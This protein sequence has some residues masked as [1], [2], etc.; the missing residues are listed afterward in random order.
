[1]LP[2]SSSHPRPLQLLLVCIVTLWSVSN[3]LVSPSTSTKTKSFV[4]LLEPE[5]NCP[6]FL[7]G[8][9]HGSQS[10]ASDVRDL[11]LLKNNKNEEENTVVVL[12][13]CAS[14]MA[15]LRRQ[16]PTLKSPIQKQFSLAGFLKMVQKTS[17]RRGWGSGVA[18]AV[19][20]GASG[21]QTALG[22]FEAGL[23]FSTALAISE[24]QETDVVLADQAVDETL[25][26]VGNLPSTSLSMLFQE[27]G[28]IPIKEAEALS[29]AVFG[30]ESLQPYQVNMPQVLTR[31][32]QVVQELLKLTLPPMSLALLAGTT[33]DKLVNAVFSPA[34]STTTQIPWWHVLQ[35]VSMTPLEVWNS[36]VG[37]DIL[38]SVLV[39][40]LGYVALALP[41]TRVILCERD[42]QL[43]AGIRAACRS[44]SKKKNGRVVAIL[45]LLHVNGVAKRLLQEQQDGSMN[46]VP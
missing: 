3:A 11:L 13:L 7:L 15:D 39:L 20:G 32:S 44:A 18:A 25:K 40:L 14:R 43:T 23:E 10:S 27:E 6:V 1:M 22:G 19:L 17:E 2:P 9:L 42:D 16:Q 24:Q 41:A 21:L 38:S 33:A 5:T 31:N 34:V 29:T 28:L 37:M 45:G 8:C 12:E 30:D 36:G 46:D 35:D 26:R 4:E